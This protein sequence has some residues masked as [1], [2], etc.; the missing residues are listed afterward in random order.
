[1]RRKCRGLIDLDKIAVHYDNRLRG[2]TV[3]VLPGSS[4]PQYGGYYGELQTQSQ[5]PRHSSELG[6]VTNYWRITTKEIMCTSHL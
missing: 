4:P 3:M 2:R 1:M 5:S 6:V